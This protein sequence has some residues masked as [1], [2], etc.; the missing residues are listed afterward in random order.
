[1]RCLYFLLYFL[2]FCVYSAKAQSNAYKFSELSTQNGLSHNWVNTVF[3]DS[4][5]FVWI[6][7]FAGLNRFDG[8]KNKLYLNNPSDNNSLHDNDVQAIFPLPGQKLWI[9]S[10]EGAVIFDPFTDNFDRDYKRYLKRLSLPQK[11]VISIEKDKKGNYWFLYHTDG[12]YKYSSS[13]NKLTYFDDKALA[14]Y[15]TITAIKEDTDGNFWL[16][17]STGLL[18]QIDGNLKI[19]KRNSLLV[20]KQPVYNYKLFTDRLNKIWAWANGEPNG[21]YKIDNDA[22]TITHFTAAS[23]TFRLNSNVIFGIVQDEKGVI[24]IGADHG[25][26]NLINESDNSQIEYINKPTKNLP[27]YDN[28]VTTLYKDDKEII[29]VGTCK[30]GVS[31]FDQNISRF[32]LL[33]H[34][35]EDH[36]SLPF[37]DV[38]CFAE[39]KKGNIWIGTDGGGLLY[40]DRV[41]N[42]FIQYLNNH[43]NSN[44]LTNNVVVSLC[45]DR[46]G[47]LWIGTYL[48][49]LDCFDGKTFTHY[50][51]NANDP[52]SLA[53]NRVWHILEDGENALWIGTMSK[54]LDKFDK[55]TNKFYHYP[56]TPGTAYPLHSNYVSVIKKDTQGNL[57]MG[58]ANGIE[59]LD[60]TQNKFTHYASAT[61]PNSLSHPLVTDILE[62]RR[63]LIWV[64]TKSGLNVF[65]Q[66][67][68]RF[69][70]FFTSNGLPDNLISNIIEDKQGDLWVSTL[71]GLSRLKIKNRNGKVSF[72]IEN[73]SEEN[74]LQGNV[75]NENAAMITGNGAILVGGLHGI[76]WINP[77]KINAKEIVPNLVF[78][79]ID[80][81]NE[82]L[83]PGEK[84]NGH[85]ILKKALTFTE[86]ISLN[87]NEDI[88]SI[89]F[90]NLNPS[91]SNKYAY[92][93]EGFNK[94]WVIVND[95]NKK[96]TY[97]NLGPGT[98]TFKVKTFNTNLE[99]G[100]TEKSLRIIINPP[101]WRTPFAF[102]VYVLVVIAILYFA[103]R[104]TIERAHMRFRM[105]HQIKETERMQA[106]DAMKTK[107]LTNV[108][109]EFRTPLNLILS[110]IQDLAEAVSEPQ[111]KQKI[112]L[113]KRNAKRLLNLVNQL[114]DFRKM[115]VQEFQLNLSE[116]D[117][118][119]FVRQTCISFSDIAEKKNIAF[120]F[121]SNVDS[122]RACFD[123]D[124]L[125]KIIFN[126]LSNAF[127]YTPDFGRVAVEAHY[128]MENIQNEVSIE[129]IVKDTGIGIPAD[130]HEKIFEPF[131][132]NDVAG[133]L[134]NHGTGIGL[135]I[136]KEF[137]RLHKGTINVVSEPEKGTTFII[138]IP[139]QKSN[140]P[141]VNLSSNSET[142]QSTPPFLP[143]LQNE[144]VRRKTTQKILL[145][146]DNED[147]RFYLKDNLNS[148][149][150]TLEACNG[151]EAWN[152]IKH[153]QPDL[154]VSD[155]MMPVMNGIEL[156]RK[157]KADPIT[158]HI[159]IILLTAVGN[160]EMQMEGYRLG[161]SDYVTKPFTFEILASR[162][163]NILSDRKKI[164]QDLLKKKDQVT[165]TDVKLTPAE[166]VLKKNLLEVVEKNLSNP[167]FTVEALS[168]E[169]CMSRVVLYRKLIAL[170][171]LT[172]LEYIRVVRI[173]RGAQLLRES[174]LLTIAEIAYEVGFN[175]PKKFTKFFK[176]EFKMLPS[177]YQQAR[178]ENT[179]FQADLP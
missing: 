158:A 171:G 102:A 72:A 176:Q 69:Q 116:D 83:K 179:S 153:Y 177:Q 112:L 39:D 79:N 65:D 80:L 12:L 27:S 130:K 11:K 145:V 37:N 140:Q 98:Y 169:L 108:S 159:P 100:K 106:L 160:N 136:T 25:G 118:I 17:Y 135:A 107:F 35:P 49:G 61:G 66:N 82:S 55:R 125:E 173:K 75:F 56:A 138:T 54:G 43:S 84:I 95:D 2:A 36:Y 121:E 19:K 10:K 152:K 8:S 111:Q 86:E 161:I 156:S 76:N 128:Q 164:Q 60:E 4:I 127:K 42:K 68:K 90:A 73:Y 137:V 26:I 97:T 51:H 148:L 168:K 58:T 109:H 7:T 103:R 144:P 46:E 38:N 47:K 157:I 85:V 78:T 40:F 6:G 74:N 20:N 22:N 93:L 143:E 24:W 30:Q 105:M 5:G 155:L 165:P 113:I 44:S 89:E 149:Y 77:E 59:V 104:I 154:I 101:L 133:N 162:I 172:P 70:R 62:D 53:D 63:G 14:S 45:Y 88:F 33:K 64:G 117:I 41:G 94:N 119:K 92:K 96:A 151:V 167:E 123:K 52:A 15:G 50:K 131:F 124:K 99:A 122:C 147:F 163:Q 48:G 67:T 13:N 175:D 71:K 21:V 28:S 150:H 23:K 87:H 139:V 142:I 115:E 16:I 166:E 178:K 146:E 31:Y 32:V 29:W 91:Y 3:R 81:F 120:C 134:L 57:W 1:M 34:D 126:L 132:Q 129:L 18:V 110:P 9:A 174:Q 114:L 141:V 170:T